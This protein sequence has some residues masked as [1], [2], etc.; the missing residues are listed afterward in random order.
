M[1]SAQ[2][3]WASGQIFFPHLFL[4]DNGIAW[5]DIKRDGLMDLG[6]P[7]GA[8]DCMRFWASP[9]IHG[10]VFWVDVDLL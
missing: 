6:E 2:Y 1:I 9:H 7:R 4:A 8:G 3:R 10:P 5:I